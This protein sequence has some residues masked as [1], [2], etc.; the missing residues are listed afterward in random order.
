MT[1]ACHLRSIVTALALVIASPAFAAD[2]SAVAPTVAGVWWTPE[3][4]GKIEIAVDPSGGVTGRLI[5]LAPADA[6]NLD[7][8]NS[9]PGL[10]ARRVLG[11]VI[12]WNFWPGK[13]GMWSGG[14]I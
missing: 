11:L 9:D 1:V 10:R 14:R 3:R 12:L 7:D 2:T 4:D 8:N 5:A 13:S 6:D